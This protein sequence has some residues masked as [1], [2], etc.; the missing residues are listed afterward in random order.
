MRAY[1]LARELSQRGHSVHWFTGRFD[2]THKQQRESASSDF[3]INPDIE[4]HLLNGPGYRRNLSF[5]RILHHRA[6]AAHFRSRA[7]QLP[8]PDCIVASH[9]SPELC[10]AGADVAGEHAIPLVV[11]VRDP[12]P[13]SFIG[14][15]SSSSQSISYPSHCLLSSHACSRISTGRS[16][17]CRDTRHA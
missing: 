7:K 8:L 5:A 2:H 14:I 10:R 12:W 16:S 3:R 17:H 6:V 9:P 13:E 1:L 11:D 4:V 15:P